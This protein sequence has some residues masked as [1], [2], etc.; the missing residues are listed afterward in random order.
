MLMDVS[1]N[2]LAVLLAGAS[3]FVVGGVWYGAL[4]AK[5]WQRL[6]GL[7][8]AEVSSGRLKV[9]GGSLV[10]S[11]IMALNLAFFIGNEG[12]GFGFFAGL[13]AGVGWVAMALGVNYL[14]ERRSRRLY[15]INAGYNAITFALMG[16]II[17]AMQR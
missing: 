16:L 3:S 17:G 12:V 10:L 9:F 1:I 11:L 4:F 7:S 6:V 15:F 14:F 5:P 2:W 8:D 13:A